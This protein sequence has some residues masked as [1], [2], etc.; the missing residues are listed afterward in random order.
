VSLPG[1]WL[2]GNE[3]TDVA[4]SLHGP[5]TVL[6]AEGNLPEAEQDC[7]D[8]L[9]HAGLTEF[10]WKS[11]RVFPARTHEE[12]GRAM[13]EQDQTRRQRQARDLFSRA[14]ETAAPQGRAG[15]AASQRGMSTGSGLGEGRFLWTS[16]PFVSQRRTRA[17]PTGP[18]NALPGGSAT[19]PE[20]ILCKEWNR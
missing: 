3:H 12:V 16:A 15:R 18:P 20:L 13:N 4:Q 7:R 11:W 14:V 10:F 9:G 8:A 6:L 5:A 19:F 17:F 2:L 1:I